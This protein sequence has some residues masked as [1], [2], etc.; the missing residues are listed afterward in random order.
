MIM[1][2]RIVR[3]VSLQFAFLALAIAGFSQERSLAAATPT[4]TISPTSASLVVYTPAAFT[5]KVTGI[6]GAG[7]KVV[8]TVNNVVGGNSSVGT[9]DPY[10][11][12]YGPTILPPGDSVTIGVHLATEPTV[13]AHATVALRNSISRVSVVNPA[14]ATAGSTFVMI[15]EGSGFAKGAQVK[16][17]TQAISTSFISSTKL[18]ATGKV[19]TPGTYNLTVTNPLP[20]GG[21]SSPITEEILS[22]TPAV[23]LPAAVRFLEQSSFGPSP[24]AIAHLQQVGFDAYLTEQFAAGYRPFVVP[25]GKDIPSLKAQYYVNALTSPAQLRMRMALALQEIIVVSANK[26]TDINGLVAWQNLMQVNALGNYGNLLRN[27]AISPAMG[28][29][30]DIAN[31]NKTDPATDVD[32]NENYAREQMQLFSIGL[33]E[34]NIDGTQKLDS[35]GNPINTYTQATVEGFASVF[36]GY[37]YPTQPGQLAL[38]NNPEYYVGNMIPVNS[39]HDETAKPLLNGTVLP[40]NQTAVTDFSL[41]ISNDFGHPNVGPFISKQLIEHLVKSNPT[42]AYVARVATV[43]NNNGSGVRG[44]LQAVAKAILL[45]P[46]ARAGDKLVVAPTDGHLQE[47]VL[48]MVGILRRLNG[49]TNGQAL[50]NWGLL[51]GE[52]ILESPTV[53]N[54]FPPTYTLVDT[55]VNGPEFALQTTATAQVRANFANALFFWNS[56]QG[57]TIDLTQY[58]AN[59]VASNQLMQL[60]QRFM[61]QSMPADMTSTIL[62]AMDAIPAN[63]TDLRARQALYLITTSGEYQ[64]LH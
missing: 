61:H 28:K 43:F 8:W 1:N 4:I 56:L 12:F 46:E 54:F 13:A 23:S 29:Y 9:I 41:G 27:V 10:G 21:V 37:T 51:M 42:P 49:T 64:V 2:A 35:T 22:T 3:A 32:P 30:L 19:L 63:E 45:D 24:Q 52:D 50:V 17:G 60:N 20:G 15:L 39:E 40:P 11:H 16:L 7:A 53:F 55:G 6:T 14:S 25:P 47:P 48:Y 18:G 26:T 58:D 59:N 38:P 5:A 31:N 62:T 34:L 44:D 33:Y 36:T 57:T